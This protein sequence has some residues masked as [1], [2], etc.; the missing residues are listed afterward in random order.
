MKKILSRATLLA[1]GTALISGFSNFLSKT[2]VTAVKDPIIFTT[3]KNS[4]V[5]LFLIGLYFVLK[6]WP[7]IKAL[8]KKQVIQ[9]GAIGLIGG[10]IPFALFF[11]GLSMT[12]ALNGALIHKTL[13]LWVLL[14]AIPLLKERV[15]RWQMVG[16]LVIFAGNI[17][18]GGFAGF[19]YNVGELMILGATILW[20]IENIIAKVVLRELSSLTVASARMVLGSFVLLGFTYFRSGFAPI[21]SLSGTQWGW[22]LLLSAFLAGYVLTWYSALKLAPATY[23]AI[24]LVPATLVTNALSAIFITHAYTL[25]DALSA[26]LFLLGIGLVTVFAR[27]AAEQPTPASVAI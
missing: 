3:L 20:A 8:T 10:S 2:A 17:V 27:D 16:V 1:L 5:A 11:T 4:A 19:K 25:T 7:E 26:G 15:T 6:R 23:V 24:L 13:F 14:F 18:I 21:F 12:S 22:T 9:L